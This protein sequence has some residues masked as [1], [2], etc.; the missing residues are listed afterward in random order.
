MWIHFAVVQALAPLGLDRENVP[1]LID[2]DHIIGH[3]HQQPGL[4]GQGM[5]GKRNEGRSLYDT[6]AVAWW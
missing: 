1:T 5:C 4:L 6:Q 3:A 2:V